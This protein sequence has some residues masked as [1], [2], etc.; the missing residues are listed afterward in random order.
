MIQFKAQKSRMNESHAG[1]LIENEIALSLLELIVLNTLSQNKGL[2]K[3]TIIN[4]IKNKLGVEFTQDIVD[5]LLDN[6]W[7]EEMICT[8]GVNGKRRYALTKKANLVKK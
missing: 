2:S 4:T 6:L 7:F 8:D 3:Q 5:A 1:G